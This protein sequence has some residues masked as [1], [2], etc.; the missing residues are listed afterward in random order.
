MRPT[1]G[2]TWRTRDVQPNPVLTW[3][4]VPVGEG[5]LLILASERDRVNVADAKAPFRGQPVGQ[6]RTT[7]DGAS[8]G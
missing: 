5:M 7:V 3:R 6:T 1:N 2:A 4:D 8:A